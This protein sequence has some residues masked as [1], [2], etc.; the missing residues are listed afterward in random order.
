MSFVLQRFG[1]IQV[2]SV[3]PILARPGPILVPSVPARIGSG[4]AETDFLATSDSW[5]RGNFGGILRDNLGEGNCESKIAARQWGVNFRCEAS[6]C[7]AGPSGW[8]VKWG[9][10]KTYGGRTMY[11]RTHS[12]EN[13][14]TPPKELLACSVVE[15][16][17]GKT[18]H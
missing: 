11:Q 6:R 16:C 5:Q 12:P 3:A 1:P 4:R 7:L 13:F 2:P 10:C 17:T 8:K 9:G 14:W 18:E 15:F